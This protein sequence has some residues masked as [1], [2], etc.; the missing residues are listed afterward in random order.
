MFSVITLLFSALL[1]FVRMSNAWR[2]LIIKK[3]IYSLRLHFWPQPKV[4]LDKLG[5][6]KKWHAFRTCIKIHYFK[7]DPCGKNG[8]ESKHSHSIWKYS[9]AIRSKITY[10]SVMYTY[11]FYRSM[12]DIEYSIAA[13]TQITFSWKCKHQVLGVTTIFQTK[14]SGR[15]Y[16]RWGVM[17]WEVCGAW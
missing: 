10:S 1:L 8:R 4:R 16:K 11:L 7:V 13:L 14:V 6:E 3:L 12:S 9:S 17:C 5:I 15:K 2:R